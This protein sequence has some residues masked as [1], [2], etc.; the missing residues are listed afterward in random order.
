MNE[1][2]EEAVKEVQTSFVEPIC[3]CLKEFSIYE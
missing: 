1:S 3:V 2:G